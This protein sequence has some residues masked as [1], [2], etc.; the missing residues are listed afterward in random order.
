MGLVKVQRIVFM[1]AGHKIHRHR[2][3][4]EG[5]KTRQ[6][7]ILILQFRAA[8]VGPDIAGQ[9][10]D[11]GIRGR[12]GLKVRLRFQMQVR[13]QLQFHVRIPPAAGGKDCAAVCTCMRNQACA[14]SLSWRWCHTEST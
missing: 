1:V 4:V 9:Y 8:L 7:E 6:A 10:Q 12:V 3:T 13:E 14:L 5:R 2:P 11:I